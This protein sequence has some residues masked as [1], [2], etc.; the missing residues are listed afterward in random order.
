MWWA[1]TG[2]RLPD[3][4]RT[5]DSQCR[6]QHLQ[7]QPRGSGEHSAVGTQATGR[8]WHVFSHL[9]KPTA[10]GA[11]LVRW[12]GC[13]QEEM[14]GCPGWFLPNAKVTRGSQ[15]GSENRSGR[16]VG[17]S[18]GA[19]D[20]GALEAGGA[21]LGNGLRGKKLVFWGQ[22]GFHLVFWLKAASLT[23]PWPPWSSHC[24]LWFL[25]GCCHLSACQ[26]DPWHK[27]QLNFSPPTCPPPEKGGCPPPAQQTLPVSPSGLVCTTH[28]PP[29][30]MTGQVGGSAFGGAPQAGCPSASQSFS[31]GVGVSG[32]V[33]GTGPFVL[34]GLPGSAGAPGYCCPNLPSSSAPGRGAGTPLLGYSG[35]KSGQNTGGGLDSSPIRAPRAPVPSLRARLQM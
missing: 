8:P 20:L 15:W 18:P 4:V 33:L 31:H 24:S 3:Y 9:H 32:P 23:S 10:P 25:L 1:V 26:G 16:L 5:S 11:F 2:H 14:S 12:A 21:G 19:T 35:P 7:G 13:S 17:K 34:S 29:L 28:A 6:P 30:A 27:C 22:K